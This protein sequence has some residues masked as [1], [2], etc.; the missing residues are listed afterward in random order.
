MKRPWRD[1]IKIS[2]R[3]SGWVTKRRSLER[4]E[5]ILK[6]RESPARSQGSL[7]C[8]LLSFTE[9][10]DKFLLLMK[11][12]KRAVL[13][14]GI[15]AVHPKIAKSRE[16][17]ISGRTRRCIPTPWVNRLAPTQRMGYEHA[18]QVPIRKSDEKKANSDG[19]CL[20][21]SLLR[22]YSRGRRRRRS[23][24]IGVVSEYPTKADALRILEQFRLR[25]NLQ[26]RLGLPITLD[27]LA[28]DYVEKELPLLRY[29]T[30]QAH[31][32]PPI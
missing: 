16:L 6:C 31:P 26:S 7:T 28:D 29:G 19:R 12:G 10:Y 15:W 23:K 32:Q 11:T 5:M 13:A 2:G 8:P 20:A 3:R 18:T 30:Q 14:R 24:I 22:N 25:L 4:R 1:F 9:G 27:A 17:P 21:V